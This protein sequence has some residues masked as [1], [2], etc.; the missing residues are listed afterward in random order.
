MENK[1]DKTRNAGKGKEKMPRSAPKKRPSSLW[2]WQRYV[3]KETQRIIKGQDSKPKVETGKSPNVERPS[4][5]REDKW[6]EKE[7]RSV[8]RVAPFHK[9]RDVK[10]FPSV[11]APEE[12]DEKEFNEIDEIEQDL[13]ILMTSSNI[14]YDD[15]LKDWVKPEIERKPPQKIPID[16]AIIKKQESKPKAKAPIKTKTDKVQTMKLF[17]E[18]VEK[19]RRKRNPKRTREHLIENL[20]DP[21]IS[22]DEAAVILNVCKTTVRR[23]TNGGKL[24]CIRTP[25]NQRRFRLST[26]LEFLEEKEGTRGLH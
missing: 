17:E 4:H 1:T 5:E 24:E 8:E 18:E 16:K 20:L 2:E 15:D 6:L 25:G 9:E 3:K 7:T 26:V 22:L 23:Y 11:I 12:I 13:D 19:A 10:P 21:I 14:E